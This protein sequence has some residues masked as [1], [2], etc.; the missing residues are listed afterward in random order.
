MQK[1]K[2]LLA[3]GFACLLMVSLLVTTAF[4][5]STADIA[6]QMDANS[7][8]WHTADAETRAKLEAENAALRE[9]LSNSGANV[10]YDPLTGST[11]VTSQN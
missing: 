11:T 5:D 8:A 9:Q 10:T 4:A 1:V 7:I 3:A 2:R 6:A